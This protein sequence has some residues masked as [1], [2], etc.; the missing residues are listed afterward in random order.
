MKVRVRILAARNARALHDFRPS[1]GEMAQGK[2]G[3]DCTRGPRATKSTGV[4]PQVNRSNAGFPCAVVYGLLRALP[5]DRAF[6][7]PSSARCAS[8]VANL[9]PASGRRRARFPKFVRY[10]GDH[11]HELRKAKGTAKFRMPVPLS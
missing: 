6:L 4:G 5:G 3:A 1:H 10:R 7:P 8:I 2:P 9:T 11:L